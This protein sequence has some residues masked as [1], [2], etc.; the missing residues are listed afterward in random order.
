MR[1]SSRSWMSWPIGSWNRKECI[2][3]VVWLDH[4]ENTETFLKDLVLALVVIETKENMG[5]I[6]K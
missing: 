4:T 2:T 3:D 1:D 5:L 6:A